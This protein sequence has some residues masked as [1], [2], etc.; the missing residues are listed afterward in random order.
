[1]DLAPV[2]VHQGPSRSI[3]VHPPAAET[4]GTM[5]SPVGPVGVE[6]HLSGLR[7]PWEDSAGSNQV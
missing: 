6:S 4:A 2:Q 5:L 7:D 3:K 1:M